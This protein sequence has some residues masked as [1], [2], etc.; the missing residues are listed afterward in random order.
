MKMIVMELIMVARA[1]NV[2]LHFQQ[3]LERLKE[4]DTK[5]IN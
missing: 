1:Y 4:E 5:A 2:M 3:Q